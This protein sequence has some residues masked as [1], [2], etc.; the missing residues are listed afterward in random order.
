MENEIFNDMPWEVSGA[1]YQPTKLG[2]VS[3]C[4]GDAHVDIPCPVN[5]PETK[6]FW[7]SSVLTDALPA[8]ASNEVP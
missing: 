3:P 6:D 1:P 4:E 8:L 2:G 5:Y 7:A